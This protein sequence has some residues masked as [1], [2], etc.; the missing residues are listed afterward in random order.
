MMLF[1]LFQILERGF[2]EGCSISKDDIKGVF[3]FF[4]LFPPSIMPSSPAF[5]C[6]MV[7]HNRDLRNTTLHLD[8]VLSSEK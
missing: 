1:S 7:Q 6:R 3:C 5:A 2:W 4:P 8:F